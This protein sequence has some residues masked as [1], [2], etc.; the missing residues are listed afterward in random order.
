MISVKDFK[1]IVAHAG[2]SNTIVKALYSHPSS[3]MQLTYIDEGLLS[4]FI[5][6][7]TGESRC[8]SVS[9]A[10]NVSRAGSKRPASRQPLEATPGSKRAAHSEMPPPPKNAAP[11][12]KSK[13]SRLSPPG[14]QPSVQSETLF[15]P[16]ADDDARWDPVNFDDEEEELLLWDAGG[17]NVDCHKKSLIT[18][19]TLSRTPRKQFPDGVCRALSL[20]AKELTVLPVWLRKLERI[21]ACHQLS[22]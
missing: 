13:I 3:P 5:L 17:D 7:T 6:M 19:L 20:K 22:A 21:L 12:L 4:E 16:E 2:T 8:A 15:I 9:L 11:S 1:S 18:L 10:A 14:A